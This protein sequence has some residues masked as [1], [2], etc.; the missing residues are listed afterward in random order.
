MFAGI[1]PRLRCLVLGWGC[2]LDINSA[3]FKDVTVLKIRYPSQQMATTDLL[4]VIRKLP[5]L[6]SLTIVK[7]LPHDT[8]ALS[9]DHDV[10]ALPY[11]KSLS[12]SGRSLVQDLDILGHLSFPASTNL[13]FH[14]DIQTIDAISALSH[15]LRVQKAARHPESSPS[16]SIS[17]DLDCQFNVIRLSINVEGSGPVVD[18]IKV[19]LSGLWYGPLQMPGTPEVVD[20]FSLLPLPSLTSFKTNFIFNVK[21]WATIFGNLP[22]LKRIS[23][24]GFHAVNLLST[25][26]Q[27]YKRRLPTSGTQTVQQADWIPIFPQLEKVELSYMTFSERIADRTDLVDALRARRNIGRPIKTFEIRKCEN[28]EGSTQALLCDCVDNLVWDGWNLP[29]KVDS[30]DDSDSSG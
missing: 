22:K 17:V 25:I 27:D 21:G 4:T 2:S 11:L 24:S 7:V 10:I 18:L 26:T 19:K 15:F 5:L 6:I 9:S 30:E 13:F 16:L 23:A 29:P 1:T 3:F 8:T 14:S 12:I 20:L 28:V